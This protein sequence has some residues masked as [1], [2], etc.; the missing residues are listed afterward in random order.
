MA[1]IDIPEEITV[2]IENEI[3]V[4]SRVFI[5]VQSISPR[6]KVWFKEQFLIYTYQQHA[7]G[8]YASYKIFP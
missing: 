3:A 7:M 6:C 8:W 5:I 4:K 1:Y 2:I